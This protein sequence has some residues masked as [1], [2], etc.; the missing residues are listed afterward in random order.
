MYAYFGH[1]KCAS[2]W[3][4]GILGQICR[5]A[6]LLHRIL[7][8]PLTPAARGPLTDY[9]RKEIAREELGRYLRTR[10]VH[11]ISCLAADGAQARSIAPER[12]FHVI[13]DPRDIIVSAYFSHRN[14]H[15]I[16]GLPELAAHREHLRSLSKEEGLL[17]E[18]AYSASEMEDLAA[19]DYDQDHVLEVK[20][21]ELTANPYQVFLEIF[22]FLG[23][24]SWEGAYRGGAKV[25]QFLR[26]MSNRLST[27]HPLLASLRRPSKITGE[28]LLGR[29]YDHRFEKKTG[30][31][32]KGR[33][34][35]QSH[36]RK[37]KAGDW[38]NH[39]TPEHVT[40]FKENFGNLAQRLNYEED[41][42][43]SLETAT[44][45]SSGVAA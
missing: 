20:M 43:W 23:L 37:G 42:D 41:N 5:E 25:R 18:M 13:R 10:G 6:G 44:T 31:R 29:V 26:V 14:S 17:A 19:W 4:H 32:E 11:F 22:E 1:H 27:H 12:A 33:T 30:G 40:A 28:M 38:R 45:S 35:A 8:D 16:E 2:T 3:I 9:H 24:L 39:F 7:V 15:P 21:E 36:Y 34:D